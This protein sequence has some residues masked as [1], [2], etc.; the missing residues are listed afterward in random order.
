MRNRSSARKTGTGTLAACSASVGRRSA[1][2]HVSDAAAAPE[3]SQRHTRVQLPSS[4]CFSL[5]S[6]QDNHR[7]Q[8]WCFRDARKKNGPRRR[9]SGAIFFPARLKKKVLNSSHPEKRK[10]KQWERGKTA[11]PRVK[12]KLAAILNPFS[13]IP[14]IPAIKL[15]PSESLRGPVRSDGVS[16]P[17]VTTTHILQN[18]PSSSVIFFWLRLSAANEIICYFKKTQ[19]AKQKK[20][21]FL[22]F[23]FCS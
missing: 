16:P 18:K 21:R 7:R 14:Q 12:V 1:E 22:G 10:V 15:K 19:R 6:S 4:W 8:A 11:A 5:T 2:R 9:F 3:D 13:S 23:F 20:S 17:S